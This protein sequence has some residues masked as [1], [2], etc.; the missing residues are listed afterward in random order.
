MVFT[1]LS[2]YL[3]I[4]WFLGSTF[5]ALDASVG[6]ADG[7][8]GSVSTIG[9]KIIF[10]I[11]NLVRKQD[12]IE[13]SW[14]R[15]PKRECQNYMFTIAPKY[16]QSAKNQ[17]PEM[18]IAPKKLKLRPIILVL[19]IKTN[20]NFSTLLILTALYKQLL[21]FD[22]L[23]EIEHLL[24]K[25]KNLACNKPNEIDHCWL[26][27]LKNLAFNKPNEIEIYLFDDFIFWALLFSALWGNISAL[28]FLHF[29]RSCFGA[30]TQTLLNPVT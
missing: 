15:A 23:N 11:G 2:F 17:R 13:S 28:L 9:Q 29:W 26:V 6:G 18:T 19:L 3:R 10:V 14:S 21:K 27:K 25:L 4:C 24:V 12:Q 1:R 20:L 8:S 16:Y 30:W 22:K 7:Q 5:K